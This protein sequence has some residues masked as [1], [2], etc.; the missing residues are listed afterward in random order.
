MPYKI[1]YVRGRYP[2]TR[3]VRTPT[4]DSAKIDVELTQSN[5][6]LQQLRLDDQTN[7]EFWLAIQL[8]HEE[9]PRDPASL[10]ELLSSVYKFVC[11]NTESFEQ[12][13]M[14]GPDL[15]YLL[16][17]ILE[18][19]VCEWT[20]DRSIVSLLRQGFVPEHKVWKYVDTTK[21]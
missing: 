10:V 4:F 3:G 2:G 8:K 5:G 9:N 21:E 16:G 18:A 11:D 14:V 20:E 1:D 13:D 7:P 17:A 6:V 15:A 12:D 19:N